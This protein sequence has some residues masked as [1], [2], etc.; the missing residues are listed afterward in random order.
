MKKKD[1]DIITNYNFIDCIA[2]SMILKLKNTITKKKTSSQIISFLM[3]YPQDI[4]LKE[5]GQKALEIY[6]KINCKNKI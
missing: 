5:I 2:L 4:D 6:N 1:I 3:K